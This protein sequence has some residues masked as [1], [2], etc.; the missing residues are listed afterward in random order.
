[1]RP[2]P[3]TI[4]LT[5]WLVSEQK[6]CEGCLMCVYAWFLLFIFYV[7][8]FEVLFRIEYIL[9]EEWKSGPHCLFMSVLLYSRLLHSGSFFHEILLHAYLFIHG[10]IVPSPNL[11]SDLWLILDFCGSEFKFSAGASSS[12]VF[13]MHPISCSLS[14]PLSLSPHSWMPLVLWGM[15][16]WPICKLLGKLTKYLQ[17]YGFNMT[18]LHSQ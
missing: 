1:M 14:C 10:P 18:W 7:H 12:Q 4:H 17:P 5:W 3:I 6:P 15:C 13:I 11:A 8:S 2:W 16:G 9:S